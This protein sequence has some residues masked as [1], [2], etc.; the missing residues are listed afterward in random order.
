MPEPPLPILLAC[1]CVCA[2]NGV[3]IGYYTLGTAIF[4]YYYF[5]SL[6]G[7]RDKNNFSVSHSGKT[8]F[9]PKMVDGPYAYTSGRSSDGGS[10]DVS[11]GGGS[12]DRSSGGGS[13]D[14]SSYAGS[15]GG[16]SGGVGLSGGSSGSGGSS[17]RSSGSGGSSS[18][19]SGTC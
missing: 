8:R 3:V 4:H 12:S 16:S 6:A 19:N 5:F 15:S 14:R 7:P 1:V 18:G 13:S 11:S 17:D 2:L 10:S 9:D